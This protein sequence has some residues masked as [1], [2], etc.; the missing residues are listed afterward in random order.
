MNRTGEP[1]FFAT[2]LWLTVGDV[3]GYSWKE[4]FPGVLR[5]G[6]WP[7]GESVLSHAIWSTP[8]C[9]ASLRP[10][11]GKSRLELFTSC[12]P[13]WQVNPLGLWLLLGSLALPGPL[14]LLQVQ[15]SLVEPV[16]KNA[17]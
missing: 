9:K 15:L 4:G 14:P 6:L 2:S 7:V 8:G 1:V 11:P 17:I 3:K 16:M 12:R 13:V 5:T 10:V